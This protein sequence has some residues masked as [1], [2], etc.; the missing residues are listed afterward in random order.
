MALGGGPTGWI[1]GLAD[2]TMLLASRV[3]F[4]QVRARVAD[5]PDAEPRHREFAH[6]EIEE[7]L[8]LR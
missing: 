3:N 5:D 7:G 8:R 6:R 1:T 2:F 4:L